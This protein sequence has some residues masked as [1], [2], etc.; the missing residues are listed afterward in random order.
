MTRFCTILILATSFFL[1]SDTVHSQ[2]VVLPTPPKNGPKLFTPLKSFRERAANGILAEATKG[3]CAKCK[4]TGK[5]CP[6]CACKRKEREEKKAE[7]AEKAERAEEAA[8]KKLEADAVK[9]ELEAKLMVEEDAKRNKPWEVH[10]DANLESPSELLKL[11]A[12]SK[13]DQDLAP[14]K[15]KALDYLASLGCNKDPKVN[16]AIMKGLKDYNVEVRMASVQTVL[17]VVQGPLVVEPEDYNPELTNLHQPVEVVMGDTYPCGCGQPQCACPEP[18]PYDPCKVAQERKERRQHRHEKHKIKKLCSRCKGKGCGSC[19]HRGQVVEVYSEMCPACC[20]EVAECMA[21]GP[22]GSGCRS[23]CSKEII[24][25]LKKMAF[26]PDPEREGCYYE[27]SLAVRNLALEALNLCPK[28]KPPI[29][30]GHGGVIE[31]GQDKSGPGGVIE[32][33]EPGNGILL[34]RSGSEPKKDDA[35]QTPT[36]ADPN[37][38]PGV[39]DDSTVFRNTNSPFSSAGFRVSNERLLDAKITQFYNRGYSLEFEGDY[40]IPEGNLLYITVPNGS[41]QVVEVLASEVGFARVSPVE[42]NLGNH[43]DS[44]I[45]VGIIE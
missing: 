30:G 13:Q 38:S 44:K 31:Q 7:E 3:F 6:A 37:G 33:G 39:D 22:Q 14:K 16:D 23:C 18:E 35:P 24:A 45:Y 34:D 40:L 36:P 12:Q 27:P 9:A 2:T 19:N 29:Q 32:S 25:E 41:S 28:A 17:A 5:L 4:L 11:A 42:G 26:D 10:D 8:L 43:R 1:C 20:P 21:C 15:Q